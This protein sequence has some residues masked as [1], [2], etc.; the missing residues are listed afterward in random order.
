M[1][2]TTVE[3]RPEEVGLALKELEAQEGGFLPDRIEMRR[4]RRRR[5]QV[6]NNF[7]INVNAE[8]DACAAALSTG[9]DVTVQG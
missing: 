4:A 1:Q 3:A 5:R 6:V 8:A 7:F 2:V 9:C